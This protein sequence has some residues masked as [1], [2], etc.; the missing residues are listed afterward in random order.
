MHS[1][2]STLRYGWVCSQWWELLTVVCH[3]ASAGQA[4][5]SSR[6]GVCPAIRL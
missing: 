1:P 3:T 6:R 2:V 5:F 4:G